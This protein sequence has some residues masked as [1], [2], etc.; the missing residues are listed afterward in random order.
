MPM[1]RGA[2]M[3]L[4]NPEHAYSSPWVR[5]QH[6]VFHLD[7]PVFDIN[8]VAHALSMNCRFNGHI[9]GFYSVASHSIMVADI[10]YHL[11]LGDPRE[12][13][14][15]DATEA[16]MTDV[17]APF[18]HVMPDWQQIDKNLER[19]MREQFSLPLTKSEGCKKADWYA[20]FVEAFCMLPGAG[21]DFEDPFG[22]RNEALE[23]LDEPRFW[24][25][26]EVPELAK[27]R[28]L[29][30]HEALQSENFEAPIISTTNVISLRGA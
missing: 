22:L 23:L 10:M 27:K 24:P 5:T 28:F 30:W 13:L 16:Y 17:P 15:H 3:K 29:W 4:E 14:L 7:A 21:E 26:P 18:K 12:G 9:S 1:T 2:E 20:L 8:D 11:K 19:A 25:A 6:G